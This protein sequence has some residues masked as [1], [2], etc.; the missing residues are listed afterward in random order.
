MKTQDEIKLDSYP[1]EEEEEEK[2][3]N[4]EEKKQEENNFNDKEDENGAIHLFGHNLNKQSPIN[5]LI[6]ILIVIVLVITLII[7]LSIIVLKFFNYLRREEVIPQ[8]MQE[9]NLTLDNTSLLLNSSNIIDITNVSQTSMAIS[10]EDVNNITQSKNTINE[11]D[12][13][14]IIDKPVSIDE[15]DL[16]SVFQM[17]LAKN[18]TKNSITKNVINDKN[19]IEVQITS[20]ENERKNFTHVTNVTNKTEINRIINARK[21]LNKTKNTLIKRNETKKKHIAIGFLYPKLTNFMISTGE[22]FVKTGKYRIYFLTESPKKKELNYNKKIKRIGKVYFNIKTIEKV[23]KSEKIDFLI[24]SEILSKNQIIS[25]K[26]LNIKLIAITEDVY[27]SSYFGMKKKPLLSKKLGL[28]DAFVQKSLEDY[29]KYKKLNL[30]NN[31]IIQNTFTLLSEKKKTSNK[32]NYNIIILGDLNNT[33]INISSLISTM[34]LVVKINSTTKL[35]IFSK[36]KPSK[37]LEQLI[38]KINLGKNVIFNPLNEKIFNYFKNSSIFIYASSKE[39]YQNILNEAK[40]YGLPC[41]ILSHFKNNKAFNKGVIKLDSFNKEKYALEIIK[42]MNDTQNKKIRNE[43]K[44]SVNIVNKEI[45][46]IWEKLFN[47]LKTGKKQF[48]ELRYKIENNLLK[49]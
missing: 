43:T 35:N 5:S 11:K 18:V 47:S 33:K 38:E 24:V 39:I 30:T 3:D 12:V 10:Q 40:A 49:K 16:K 15:K 7:F 1:K 32:T 19:L 6:Y 48:K 34:E 2:E 29:K 42:L 44:L 13:K 28:F 37:E 25:L 26:S 46:K 4:D 23:S 17:P 14:N 45:E 27:L 36:D 31:I 20:N 22:Y 21:I 41:I 8:F 9:Q